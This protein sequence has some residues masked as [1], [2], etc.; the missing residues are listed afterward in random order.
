MSSKSL[1]PYVIEVED[2]TGI[3]TIVEQ[4]NQSSFTADVT[5]KRYFLYSFLKAAEG[6]NPGTFRDDYRKL[7]LFSTPGI[8]RS[9]QSKIN[10]RN[11]NSPSAKIGNRG[12]I[13]VA[14]KS[15]SFSSPNTA[16]IRFR[17]KNIGSTPGFQDNRDMI[18]DIEFK[19]TDLSLSSEERYI[20]PLGFQVIK[21][22]VDEELI[23]GSEEKI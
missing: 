4:L 2:K 22:V 20:N 21:Y 7:A 15:I 17:L 13:D 19:F 23:T 10:P 1:V 9:I 3:P 18:A 14:L 8:F 11:E 16:I 5:L 12:M 6:Y